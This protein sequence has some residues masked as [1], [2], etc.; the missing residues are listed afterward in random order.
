M[1]TDLVNNDMTLKT[2]ITAILSEDEPTHRF[3]QTPEEAFE[4]L[5]AGLSKGL[6]V[7]VDELHQSVSLERGR[8]LGEFSELNVE[9]RGPYC[10][11]TGFT[12]YCA[13][14]SFNN[15]DGP[16]HFLMDR[17]GNIRDEIEKL[18]KKPWRS[19][20]ECVQDLLYAIRL[21]NQGTLDYL[22]DFLAGRLDE[23]NRELMG[24]RQQI[25]ALA[26]TLGQ[27]A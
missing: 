8:D 3:F 11:N 18:N 9:L 6:H 21:L 13:R 1:S 20:E 17:G 15:S 19:M 12:L 24:T 22:K 23:I 2:N 25:K 5:M 26:K 10:P 27:N 16:C 7:S 4:A 14:Q